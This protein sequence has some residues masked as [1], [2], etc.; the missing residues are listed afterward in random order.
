MQRNA[1]E[2]TAKNVCNDRIDVQPNVKIVKLLI[3]FDCHSC[4][5]SS[6]VEFFSFKN[7]VPFLDQPACLCAYLSVCRLPV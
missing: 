1:E 4:K 7:R 5:P 3:S 2:N 6:N